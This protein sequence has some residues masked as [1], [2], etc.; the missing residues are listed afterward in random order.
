MRV[1]RPSSTNESQRE[2]FIDWY[3]RDENGDVV[4]T[5]PP[6]G[7]IKVV[8]ALRAARWLLHR[9]GVQKG[10]PADVALD[11][12][13][14]IATVRWALDEAVRGRS[15]FRRTLGAVVLLSALWGLRKTLSS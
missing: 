3:F 5:E 13:G 1:N 10:S 2:N 15:N 4:L 6:N 9:V 12:A 8:Y 14:T 7:A 11:L